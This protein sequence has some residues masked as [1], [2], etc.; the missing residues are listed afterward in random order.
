MG[1]LAEG[2][3]FVT[4]RERNHNFTDATRCPAS[5]GQTNDAVS[6]KCSVRKVSIDVGGG[7]DG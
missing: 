7:I 5:V 3:P 1:R 2:I 4:V 6:V